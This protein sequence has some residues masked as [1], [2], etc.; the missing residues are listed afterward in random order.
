MHLVIAYIP[1]ETNKVFILRVGGTGL[2]MAVTDS[3]LLT[4]IIRI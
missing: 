4:H 3:K 2:S 1:I